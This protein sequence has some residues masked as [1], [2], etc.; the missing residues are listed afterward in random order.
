LSIV[1]VYTVKVL[2][3]MWFIASQNCSTMRRKMACL[4]TCFLGSFYTKPFSML[5]KPLFTRLSEH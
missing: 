5:C 3:K 4:K 2:L 1:A